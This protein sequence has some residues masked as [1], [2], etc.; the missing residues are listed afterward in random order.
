MNKNRLAAGSN[1][2]VLVEYCQACGA[3]D[4]HPVFFAGYLPP[5]NT[6][7]PIGSRAAEQPA[8]PAQVLLCRACKLVQLGL[9]VDP[10]ILFPP[11]YPYTSGTTR[12][13]RENFAELYRDF[14]S[15]YPLAKDDLVR[16]EER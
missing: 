2:S 13:L 12:I 14:T 7:P 5:V 11:S 15:R 8:Y 3:Q 4:F 16:S 1:G 6:M 9:V 10:A